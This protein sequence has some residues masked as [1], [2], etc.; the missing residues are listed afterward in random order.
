MTNIKICGITTL[1]DG[2]LAAGVGADLIGLNCYPPSPRFLTPPQARALTDALRDA[3]GEA[4]PVF[5]GV[6][7]NEDAA[8]MRR[9]M[10]QTGLDYAQLSGDEPPDVLAALDGR[11]FKAIRPRDAAEA[12]DLAAA[13]LLHAPEDAH[14]PA[15]LVDAYHKRLYGG[16]G[17]LAGEAVASAVLP[18]TDRLMLAGGLTP[19]NVAARITAIRPWGVDVASGVEGDTPGRKDE[20]CLRAF[21][22]AVRLADG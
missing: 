14:I 9:I 20:A 1:E 22:A 5:V 13:F 6:F 8:T 12:A 21:A 16:T 3:L 7:V 18:L 4:C 15:L 17:E 19:D 2:L 11:G 10:E